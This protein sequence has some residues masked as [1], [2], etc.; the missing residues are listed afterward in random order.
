MTFTTP[1]EIARLQSITAA[2]R[3]QER[4]AQS[5]ALLDSGEAQMVGFL[6][7][8]AFEDCES[9]YDVECRLAASRF[10]DL[11]K[12]IHGIRPS[13]VRT[14]DLTLTALEERCQ[15]LV[16]VESDK[17]LFWE[18]VMARQEE[19]DQAEAE[20]AA[21]KALEAEQDAVWALQDRLAGVRTAW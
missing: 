21:E 18:G 8:D 7:E 6:C 10:S 9:G 11:Y 17:D 13:W 4:N 20:R 16:E 12:E 14:S 3:V 5:Q 1:T 2:Q 15:D 19:M